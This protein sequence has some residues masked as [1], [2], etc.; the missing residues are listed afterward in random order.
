MQI[1]NPVSYQL[2]FPSAI[3]PTFSAQKSPSG[4]PNATRILF[5]LLNRT[6]PRVSSPASVSRHLNRIRH[7]NQI[8]ALVPWVYDLQQR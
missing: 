6:R 8:K 4:A 1:I 7:N 5:Q 2:R 3:E